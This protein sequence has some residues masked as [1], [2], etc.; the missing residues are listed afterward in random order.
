[1]D[2]SSKKSLNQRD[3]H[4]KKPAPLPRTKLLTAKGLTQ[5]NPDKSSKIA[6]VKSEKPIDGQYR[7]IEMFDPLLYQSEM[8]LCGHTIQ[9]SPLSECIVSRDDLE[10]VKYN[11]NAIQS[12]TQFTN[13]SVHQLIS[14]L[15]ERPHSVCDQSRLTDVS[16]CLTNSTEEYFNNPSVAK[17]E[18]NE[19]QANIF[20]KPV[21]KVKIFPK[22]PSK[23]LTPSK[24]TSQISEKIFVPSKPPNDLNKTSSINSPFNTEK[25]LMDDNTSCHNS[26]TQDYGTEMEVDF[27]NFSLSEFDPLHFRNPS[28]KFQGVSNRQILDSI[29]IE[30]TNDF[31]DLHDNESKQICIREYKISRPEG[32]VVTIS[33]PKVVQSE[34]NSKNTVW[35]RS[36]QLELQTE[37][38][39]MQNL[40]QDAQRVGCGSPSPV[41]DV[42]LSQVSFAD[43]SAAAS[44]LQNEVL[45]VT[46]CSS[47]DSEVHVI[48]DIRPST[49]KPKSS[50][51]SKF[52]KLFGVVSEPDLKTLQRPPINN[53][54]PHF[55]GIM[56]WIADDNL[57]SISKL[58]YCALAEQKLF[59]YTDSAMQALKEVY[60]LNNVTSLQMVLPVECS[61][62]LYC[63][64]LGIS[65][66]ESGIKNSLRVKIT[67]GCPT[68]AERLTWAQ[69]IAANLTSAFSSIN[70]SEFTRLGWCYLKVGVSGEWL[71]AWLL[72]AGR[73]LMYYCTEDIADNVDL[74]KT[75]C[76]GTQTADEESKKACP[77]DCCSNLLLDCSVTTLYLRFP[78]TE[79]FQNWNCVISLAAHSNGLG[80]DEQQLTNEEVPTIVDKCINFIYAYG[81]LSEGIYRRAGSSVVLGEL[82]TRFRADAWSVQL[83][84]QIYSEHDVAG[85]FKRFFR[86]LPTPL[87]SR[88]C[89]DRLINALAIDDNY[90]RLE[91]YQRALVSLSPV[92]CN[93]ARKLFAHLN[94]IHKWNEINKMNAENLAAVWAPTIMPPCVKSTGQQISWSENEVTVVRDIIVN[95]QTVWCPDEDEIKR[96]LACHRVIMRMQESARP[97]PQPSSAGDLRFWVFMDDSS[98]HFQVSLTPDKTSA[99]VCKE[100]SVKT[101]I[102]HHKLM[103]EE[104]ICNGSLKR[105]VHKDEIV[106]DVVTRWGY[107]D[108]EDRKDNNLVIKEN[109]ILCQM[110]LCQM[111]SMSKNGIQVCGQ[112]RYAND[113]TKK[114]KSY[115]FEVNSSKLSSYADSQGSSKVEEW[116]INDIIW[117]FGHEVKR[118]PQCRW[119]ITF[120]PKNK[121]RRS[122]DHPYFGSTI[123]GGVTESQLQW[124]T[125]LMFAEH[126]TI[127]PMPHDFLQ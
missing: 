47:Q 91:E 2:S 13:S 17:I 12:T 127:L 79:E 37:C 77:S 119:A 46:S 95:Y 24:I 96:D 101:N 64:E 21:I 55:N 56:T 16:K 116:D 84:P 71:A 109:R 57:V 112:L 76:L 14:P 39:T 36:E 98:N 58:L 100:L 74:R 113:A 38:M 82:L 61:N 42:A 102:P 92:S 49:S 10:K 26:T 114:F 72:L 63:F 44:A 32:E 48:E 110:D 40:Q 80:L 105:I 33:D 34:P 62:C 52:K 22:T 68:S 54:G 30:D 115:V 122:K 117:Y 86:D 19:D 31:E 118:D 11:S 93:T 81:V 78:H 73:E 7:N 94:F 23:D 5:V 70:Y 107:W 65:N 8:E 29:I 43:M 108:D 126:D 53:Y 4:A 27:N 124:A 15:L 6:D 1:M 90:R 60:K 51:I 9:H 111:D 85:V 66:L 59:C 3:L 87:I 99:D 103:L 20:G 50:T 121:K 104:Q 88:E 120:I 89:H 18:H 97:L 123:A 35:V 106:L 28:S 41:T 25:D 125:A 67:F 69:K 75:R 83:T 45:D